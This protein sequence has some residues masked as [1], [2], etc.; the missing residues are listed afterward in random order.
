ML[1]EVTRIGYTQDA[2]LSRMWTIHVMPDARLRKLHPLVPSF[3]AQLEF[4]RVEILDRN[5]YY[6]DEIHRALQTLRIRSC[7]SHPPTARHP[8]GFYL[9]PDAWASWVGDGE[10]I[11]RYGETFL[12]D[13][14]Q[15]DVL[16]KLAQSGADERHAVIVVTTGQ[17]GPHPAVDMRLLPSSPPQ[18]HDCID[19]LWIIASQ[20]PPAQGCYWSRDGG[21]VTAALPI[22]TTLR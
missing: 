20:A 19:W 12:A 3:L 13:A 10:D 17:L 7:M 16:R 1:S 2:R 4:L 5:R 14:A 18:I 6:G 8:P 11:R 21:W 9:L 15:A 22:V